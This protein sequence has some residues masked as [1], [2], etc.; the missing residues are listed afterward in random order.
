MLVSVLG[1]RVVPVGVGE[2][3]VR[4]RMAVPHTLR[5]L[6]RMD[7]AMVLVVDVD[8]LMRD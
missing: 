2:F 6:L 7:V 4:V 5:D 1:V 3:L 8:M